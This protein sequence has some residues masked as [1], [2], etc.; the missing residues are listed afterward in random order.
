MRRETAYHTGK[1]LAARMKSL[2]TAM[3]RNIRAIKSNLKSSNSTGTKQGL[4]GV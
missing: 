4:K 3:G 1:E 2:E